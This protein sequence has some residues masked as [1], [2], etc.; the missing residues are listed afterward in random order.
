MAAEVSH[1]I[2]LFAE[3]IM[4]VGSFPITN[5]LL[6]SWIVVIVLVT[7]AFVLRKKTSVVPKK[8]QSIFEMVLEQGLDLADL[9]TNSRKLSL[10]IFPIAI[11]VFLFVLINNWLGFFPGVGS[12]GFIQNH[13]GQDILIPLLRGGTAD[14]N[15]TIAL[16][17]I[18][19]IGANIFGVVML[20]VW[21]LINKYINLDVLL[22][23]PKKISADPMIL[24][25]APIH[26][27]VGIFEIIGEFAKIASLSFRLFGNVF[28]GEVLLMSMAALVPFIIPIPFLF[29]EVFVGFI[30]AI[31]FSLLTIVYF[32]IASIDHGE[33]TEEH[34]KSV[35]VHVQ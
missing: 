25:T 11:I 5:A 14:I 19:V 24:V 18:S 22:S 23:I 29:L 1:G 27:L 3:P 2:T 28:A 16:G 32:T 30:Q 20:G 6:M 8:F 13:N 15:T 21:K 12:I 7:L 31:I 17:L 26:F 9:V 35:T 33:H 4:S 34:E 10:K